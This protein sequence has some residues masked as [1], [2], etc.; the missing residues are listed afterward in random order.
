MSAESDMYFQSTERNLDQALSTFQES[1]KQYGLYKA[2]TQADEQV[3]KLKSA[4]MKEQDK[5]A[6]M[7]SIARNLT[8]QMFN[9]GANAAQIEQA[10]API[11]SRAIASADDAI[12]RGS[13]AGDEDLIQKGLRADRLS[14]A[15]KLAL[16]EAKAGQEKQKE[17][18]Q[19]DV[20]FRVNASAAMAN[21][22]QLESMVKRYGNKESNLS[23]AIFSNKRA[24]GTLEALYYDTAVAYA[25]IVDPT[26]V[27]RE[28]EV[29]AAKKYAIASGWFTSND[30]TLAGIA[31]MRKT[32]ASRAK[33]RQALAAQ[34]KLASQ[35]DPM[36]TLEDGRP[37]PKYFSR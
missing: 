11:R 7:D 22:G 17:L 26:S 6:A 36:T 33:D 28:G 15:N 29:E 24:A 8:A 23:P 21:L 2:M 32:I 34:G 13:L 30:S 9:T 37:V 27:A 20:D 14:A 12:L 1:A 4:S 16:L 19:A 18:K 35:P 25:K 10:A 3:N 31:Q 5:M